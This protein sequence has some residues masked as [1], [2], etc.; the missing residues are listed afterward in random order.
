M[1]LIFMYVTPILLLLLQF[2]LR[3]SGVAYSVSC[4]Y[5]FLYVSDKYFKFF[6]VIFEV[7]NKENAEKI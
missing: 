5:H 7:E 3:E 2:V 1:Y 6:Q 4:S